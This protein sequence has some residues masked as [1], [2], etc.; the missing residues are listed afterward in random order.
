MTSDQ[1]NIFNTCEQDILNLDNPFQVK[2]E[3]KHTQWR[4]KLFIIHHNAWLEQGIGIGNITQQP[5]K[6]QIIHELNNTP[7][8]DL[9]ITDQL[10]YSRQKRMLFIQ[11]LL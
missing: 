8:L 7:L 6:I 9:P 3:P 11:S 2:V 5:F 10:T 4:I 1:E